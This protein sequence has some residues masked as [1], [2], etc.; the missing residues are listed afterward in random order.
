MVLSISNLAAKA[1]CDAI[2][3]LCDAGGSPALLRIYS[4]T[5]PALLE[6]ALS[7]NT[8]LAELTMSATAFGPSVDAN[9]G[10]RATA[11]A[12]TDDSSANNNGIATFFRIVQG[13]TFTPVIQGL[14]GT[15]GSGAELELSSLTILA[16]SPISVTSLTNTMPE[17]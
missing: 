4:G 2:L 10:A 6:D 13:T 9:P 14:C 17:G 11:N 3:A 16:G 12:I 15:V 5:A 8:L 1:A 7:G